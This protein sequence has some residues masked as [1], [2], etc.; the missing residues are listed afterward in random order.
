MKKA[1]ILFFLSLHLTA[2]SQNTKFQLIEKQVLCGPIL[3][4][5]KALTH[6]EINEK[7]LWVGKS[8]DDDT[9]FAVVENE[10][11]K[12]FTLLQYTKNWACVLGSGTESGLVIPK[13]P[14]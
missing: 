5:I 4:V 3:N 2:F 9:F 1:A 14:N 6:K 11:T 8:E 10:S 12:T 13:K 7:P